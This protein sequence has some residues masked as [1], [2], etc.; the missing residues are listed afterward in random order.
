MRV[1]AVDLDRTIVPNGKEPYDGSLPLLTSIIDEE[2]I[3]LIYVTAR[4]IDSIK[5]VITEYDLPIPKYIISKVGALIY[6]SL[7][8]KYIEIT[9]WQDIIEDNSNLWDFNGLKDGLSEVDN[10]EIQKDEEQHRFKLSYYI[11][12][13][14]GYNKTVDVVSS[15]SHNISG[16]Y[17]EVTASK[18]LNS[19][20]GYIDIMP[21]FLSKLS[22]L[23]F[24]QDIIGFRDDE[25]LFAGDSGNDIPVLQSHFD[26][27]LVKNS[28][29]E[30]KDL[31]SDFNCHIAKGIG[32][33]NGNYSSGI[34]EGII[35]KG[36]FS[37]EKLVKREEF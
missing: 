25:I 32:G 29:I 12:T 13:L 8:D 26:S 6:K 5:S 4:R 20:K 19:H 7:N 18:D 21:P 36:W 11:K 35:E 23:L 22:A 2:D 27:I 17:V 28:E 30:L 33:L 15:I 34:I 3:L 16:D 1:L 24:L 31:C 9:A 14:D 10:L 37:V